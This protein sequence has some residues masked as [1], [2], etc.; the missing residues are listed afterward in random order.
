MFIDLFSICNR[1]ERGVMGEHLIKYVQSTLDVAYYLEHMEVLFL[2]EA[3]HRSEPTFCLQVYAL[4]DVCW[5]LYL[6]IQS[7]YLF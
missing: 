4:D 6:L 1:E 7:H 3:K 5:C 2:Q